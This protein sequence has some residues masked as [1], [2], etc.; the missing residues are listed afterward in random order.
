MV[1]YPTGRTKISVEMRLI[2]RPENRYVHLQKPA[3]LVAD[4][5]KRDTHVII[6]T[7]EFFGENKSYNYVNISNLFLCFHVI[8]TDLFFSIF[9]YNL[10]HIDFTAISTIF[11]L[12][13]DEL[14]V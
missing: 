11:L 6:K 3:I 9:F 1:V 12:C 13:C 14:A 8:I 4:F 7:T 2:S 10:S 5:I